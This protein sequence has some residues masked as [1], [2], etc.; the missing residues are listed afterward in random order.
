MTKI[1]KKPTHTNSYINFY[2]SA[3]LESEIRIGKVSFKKSSIKIK[4]QAAK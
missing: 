2:L 1:Y 3:F 4:F